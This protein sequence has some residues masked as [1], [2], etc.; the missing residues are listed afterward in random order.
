MSLLHVMAFFEGVIIKVKMEA[1]LASIAA[2]SEVPGLD[3]VMAAKISPFCRHY[4][5]RG[6]SFLKIL[7]ETKFKTK[8]SRQCFLEN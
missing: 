6:I 4:P 2:S 7:Q 3:F 1:Y 8:I 5:L